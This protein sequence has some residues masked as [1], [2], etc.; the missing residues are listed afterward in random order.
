MRPNGKLMLSLWLGW[1]GSGSSAFELSEIIPNMP[2][3]EQGSRRC[4]KRFVQD[5]E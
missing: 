3:G 4:W 1:P 5:I 2:A